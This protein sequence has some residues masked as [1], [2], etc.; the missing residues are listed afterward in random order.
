[1]INFRQPIGIPGTKS[2]RVPMWGEVLRFVAY[3]LIGGL[4]FF[5]LSSQHACAQPACMSL[6]NPD[7]LI[8]EGNRVCDA[9]GKCQTVERLQRSWRGHPERRAEFYRKLYGAEK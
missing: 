6:L 4:L 8:C 1:M 3:P 9:T 2:H 5:W 7:V